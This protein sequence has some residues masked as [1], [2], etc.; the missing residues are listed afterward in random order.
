MYDCA[1]IISL[2][3]NVLLSVA[4]DRRLHWVG[5]Y[6]QGRSGLIMSNAVDT[7]LTDKVRSDWTPSGVEMLP[8]PASNEGPGP[9]DRPVISSTARGV[10]SPKLIKRDRLKLQPSRR[11]PFN[12][13]L[14]KTN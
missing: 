4:L 9:G 14:M 1:G 3:P 11:I 8:P 12:L 10:F 2:W 13:Q 6:W 7:L 5:V